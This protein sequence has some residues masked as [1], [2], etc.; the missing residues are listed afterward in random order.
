MS[1]DA[2]ETDDTEKN[3][4]DEVSDEKVKNETIM[5]IEEFLVNRNLNVSCWNSLVSLSQVFT[6]N[7]LLF[8]HPNLSCY[9]KILLH[10][11][12]TSSV[13]SRLKLF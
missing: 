1:S 10:C 9:S 8:F 2:A 11:Y 12:M 5:T 3:V 7:L 13:L 4:T 6:L